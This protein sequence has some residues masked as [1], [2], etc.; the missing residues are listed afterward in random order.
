VDLARARD[1]FWSAGNFSLFPP[2]K[3]PLP[4]SIPVSFDFF[5]S[6]DK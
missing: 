6:F 1:P 2:E 5:L 4:G 3:L